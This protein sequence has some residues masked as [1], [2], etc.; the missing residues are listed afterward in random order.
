MLARLLRALPRPARLKGTWAHRVL[1]ER[2]FDRA[3]WRPESAAVARGV[4]I[5]VFVALTPA[6]G[7]HL[8]LAVLGAFLL[9]GNI[10]AALAAVW[11][12]NPL[13]AVPILVAEKAIGNWLAA[14]LK[15][16][17]VQDEV[18]QDPRLLRAAWSVVLGSTA[19]AAMGSLAAYGLVRLVARVMRG[20]PRPQ[21][22][23]REPPK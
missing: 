14:L 15:R 9:R 11:I 12:A 8:A 23:R 22:F 19:A 18:S 3:L 2:L 20:I 5:G 1:G 16:G 13:T 4:A 10:P 21:R 7:L 6:Y 17:F